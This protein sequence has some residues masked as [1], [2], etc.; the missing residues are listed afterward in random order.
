MELTD[1]K[2]IFICPDHNE[3]FHQ[4]KLHIE[5]L[6]KQLGFK[7]VSHYKSSTENYPECLTYAMI[8]IL[9]QHLNDEPLFI[10]E[11]DVETTGN[12]N[13]VLDKSADAIYIGLSSCA[14][15]KTE[16]TNRGISQFVQFSD[17]QVRILNMLSTHAIIYISKQYKQAVI[18][19]LKAHLGQA[20]HSDILISRIQPN[21]LIL[22]N[23]K[24]V[25]YQSAKF[26]N[27][28]DSEVC[29]N[30]MV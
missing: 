13:V 14:G 19:T 27:T 11:D 9:E 1:I 2:T 3:K 26:N 12:M 22:A 23:K 15:D 25:F 4:R 6:L 7:N 21:F 8:D 10:V 16:N 20:Y 18:D 29:T 30:V 24:P 5:N 17:T 28:I